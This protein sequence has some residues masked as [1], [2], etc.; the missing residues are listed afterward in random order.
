MCAPIWLA[1]PVIR[2][3][4]P[5]IFILRPFVNAITGFAVPA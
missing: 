2:N 3:L 5:L 4:P 1:P